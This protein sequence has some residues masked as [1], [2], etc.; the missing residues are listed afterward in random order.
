M[1]VETFKTTESNAEGARSIE[2]G[3]EFGENLDA[4]A[5]KFGD[6]VVMANFTKSAKISL[7]A[8]V[9]DLMKAGKTDEEI[10]TYVASE[11]VP[12]LKTAR[13]QVSTAEKLLKAFSKLPAEEQARILGA[14]TK[15]AAA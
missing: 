12:G 2:L 1:A 9:R 4:A 8:R 3:Y 5:E 10:Q 15:P 13:V 11:W 6:D 14:L 7:Q